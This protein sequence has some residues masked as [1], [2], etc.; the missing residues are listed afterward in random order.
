MVPIA[1]EVSMS[2]PSVNRPA[3]EMATAIPEKNTARPAVPLATSIAPCLSRPRRR[4][5][6]KR[7]MMNSE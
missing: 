4:S 2:T 5:E 7:V 6:R 1:I 3:M